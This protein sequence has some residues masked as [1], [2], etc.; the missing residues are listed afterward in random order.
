[1]ICSVLLVLY[2][3]VMSYCVRFLFSPCL[4]CPFSLSCVLPS[5]SLCLSASFLPGL[6]LCAPPLRYHTWLP[7]SSLSSPVPHLVI[8]V[9][10]FRLFSPALFGHCISM[11]LSV[12]THVPVISF[13]FPCTMFCFLICTLSSF[14]LLLCLALVL[15]LWFWS[16]DTFSFVVFG[17]V[18]LISAL[19]IKARLLFPQYCLP[20]HELLHLG[21][22]PSIHSL[23]LHPRPDTNKKNVIIDNPNKT[24]FIKIHTFANVPNVKEMTGSFWAQLLLHP[25]SKINQGIQ[26]IKEI[27]LILASESS[28]RF[29]VDTGTFCSCSSLPVYFCP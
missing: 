28:A 17:F 25:L 2:L 10:V 16:S 29:S 12:H 19:F 8:S 13:Q 9:C 21:P 15:L 4:M 7:P 22:P 11:Y 24:M 26:H 27:Y 3:F 1:M 5:V 18:C 6:L 23:P 14:W 20:F